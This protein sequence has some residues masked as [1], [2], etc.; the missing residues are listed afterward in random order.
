MRKRCNVVELLARGQVASTVHRVGVLKVISRSPKAIAPRSLLQ[1]IRKTTPIDKVTLYRILDLFVAKKI[2]RRMTGQKGTMCYEVMCEKHN[3]QHPHF[4]CRT[5]G[6]MECL[7]GIDISD[8]KQRLRHTRYIEEE[9]IDLKLEGVCGK[10]RTK[11]SFK[12]KG[13]PV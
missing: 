6:D 4:V 10:C 9:A 7:E 8:V 5:C 12:K 11:K 3:P 1:E 2:L 13:S